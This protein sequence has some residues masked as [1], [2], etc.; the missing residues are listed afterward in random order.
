MNILILANYDVGLYKFRKELIQ[1]LLK[2][3]DKVTISLPYG[4]CIPALVTMGCEFIDT[5]VDRRGINPFIDFKLILSYFKIIHRTKPNLVITYT[6]KPNIYGGFVSRIK[7]IPYVVNITG[8]GTTFQKDG[9]LK[10]L[11]KHLYKIA[12]KNVKMMF[13]EN[14]EN[15]Q[16]F[17]DNNIIKPENTF[18][19]KGAGVNLEEY[20]YCE[21]PQDNEIHFLFIGRVMK[22][23]GIDELF[24]A[25]K[26]LKRNY[27]S[28]VF[29]IVGLPEANYDK[30]IHELEEQ[31]V[32][33]YHGYQADVRPFIKKSHCLVLPSYHEGMANVLLEAAS[34]GRPLITSNISGC[35]E[36]V[37]SSKNGYLVNKADFVSLYQA[38]EDFINKPNCDKRELG[39]MSR[40]YMEEVFDKNKVV[41]QTIKCLFGEEQET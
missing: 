15:R 11:I 3:G 40:K 26:I 13:F 2:R 33:K 23:K 32:I 29:D 18:H 34:M 27:S 35:R 10:E 24:A 17:I 20:A 31:E 14:E 8:L 41:R 25:A 6:I 19:L 28:V 4:D 38:M 12:C 5:N 36:A 7:A 39:I 22:E 9:L 1:E 21:Y 16:I 37:Y 30:I